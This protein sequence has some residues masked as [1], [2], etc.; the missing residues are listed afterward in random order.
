MFGFLYNVCLPVLCLLNCVKSAYLYSVCLLCLPTCIMSAQL[1]TGIWL[2][3]LSAF[4][5]VWLLVTMMSGCWYEIMSC[6]LYDVFLPEGCLPSCIMFGNLYIW[7]LDTCTSLATCMMFVYLYSISAYLCD[8]YLLVWSLPN[9]LC[10]VPVM[11]CYLYN[12]CLTRRLSI[13]IY[14]YLHDVWGAGGW[15]SFRYCCC[16]ILPVGVVLPVL[17]FCLPP[18]P[19][20]PSVLSAAI[21]ATQQLYQPPSSL[22]VIQVCLPPSLLPVGEFCQPASFLPVLTVS[23]DALLT[24][25]SDAVPCWFFQIRPDR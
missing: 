15:L 1:Y 17:H 24:V 11:F 12:V 19:F 18:V 23:S 3:V 9:A 10:P 22:P 8:N 13:Y 4:Y 20:C 25:S 14:A 2:P 5:V 6:H 7:W 21:S 16:P